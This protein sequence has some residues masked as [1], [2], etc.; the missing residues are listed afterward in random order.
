MKRILNYFINKK[1]PEA[2]W[3]SSLISNVPI[4]KRILNNCSEAYSSSNN[5]V[6]ETLLFTALV[7]SFTAFS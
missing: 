6:T 7:I 4:M 5:K 2:H 3:A 1:I